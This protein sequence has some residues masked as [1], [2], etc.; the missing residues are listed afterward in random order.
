MSLRFII[1]PSPF[2]LCYL[3]ELPTLSSWLQ[4]YALSDSHAPRTVRLPEQQRR[5]ASSSAYPPPY[6]SSSQRTSRLDAQ[7][8]GNYRSSTL[9]L[10][11][12]ILLSLQTRVG[13]KIASFS[14]TLYAEPRLWSN[15]CSELEARRFLERYRHFSSLAIDRS[16]RARA[17]I[18]GAFCKGSGHRSRGGV[19]TDDEF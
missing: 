18:R 14:L 2:A 4:T 10:A 13:P 7:S 1:P 8:L 17:R 15:S 19:T 16:W 9:V 6:L 11:S 5:K 3:L 12:N